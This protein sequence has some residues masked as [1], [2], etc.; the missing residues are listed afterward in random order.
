MEPSSI[1]RRSNTSAFSFGNRWVGIV[2]LGTP[3]APE[4]LHKMAL[5]LHQ[6]SRS[7]S[8]RIDS[9][10]QLRA[11][12]VL[13]TLIR[14]RQ[15]M[16]IAGLDTR[17]NECLVIERM[18]RSGRK[19]QLRQWLRR[20]IQTVHA[21][22]RLAEDARREPAMTATPK[23]ARRDVLPPEEIV[24]T[25]WAES[26]PRAPDSA[27]LP[28]MRDALADEL[29]AIGLELDDDARRWVQ[30]ACLHRSYVYE[31]IPDSPVSAEPLELLAALGKGWMRMA[32]LDRVRAQRGEF[33]SN[34]EVSAVFASDKQ[35]RHALA[36]W[37]TTI[38]AASFGR[39]EA[40]LLAA[41]SR[42]TA[43]EAVALQILGVLSMATASQ[44]PADGLLERLDLELEAPEPE[45]GTLLASQ[46]KRSPG[47]REPRSVPT[48][49]N[50]SRSPSRRGG[51]RH[52][53]RQPRPKL[54]VSWPHAPTFVDSCPARFPPLRWVIGRDRG[55]SRY[56]AIGT[57]TTAR[58]S[59]RNRRS[60]W[61]AAA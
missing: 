11:D 57:S 49:T 52:L 51:A 7:R 46:V 15:R 54:L 36:Q 4:P 16:A 42:S 47:T 5:R 41:G 23:S 9:Q 14:I 58:G 8:I 17:A 31:S 20:E 40:Q 10:L 18:I 27:L 22:E 44:V 39:G 30:W 35:V 43:P 25:D 28:A 59:G 3:P 1:T 55:L 6:R 12:E 60:R 53:A 56:R 33:E 34:N 45:W 37:I 19:P 29:K 13:P 61:L 21:P 50:S 24:A 26:C 48:T 32:L 2:A 38:D